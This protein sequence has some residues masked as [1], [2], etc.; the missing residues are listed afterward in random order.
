MGKWKTISIREELTNE[1]EKAIKTG[2][3]RST[4][5]FVSEA[6]RLRLEEIMRT[7]GLLT[8]KH[9]MLET[10]EMVLYSPKHTWVQATPE[11]NFRVGLSEYAAKH[12][13][14][15]I[16][17]HIEQLDASVKKLEPLGAV[18]T[19]MFMFDVYSPISGKI[20]KINENLKTNPRIINEDPYGQGWIVEIKPSNSQTL[21]EELMSLMA[22]RE[23][24]KWVSKLEG[25]LRE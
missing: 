21:E 23:Y 16:Q 5:E 20:V 13:K 8:E 7:E 18:E 1:V 14:G 2:R 25:R 3:Y 11:G 4:S 9:K 17:V 15:I 10:P 19:W 22:V 12:L 24:N 6:I